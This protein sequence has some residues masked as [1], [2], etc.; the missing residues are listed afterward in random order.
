[1]TLS[2]SWLARIPP[3]SFEADLDVVDA[4]LKANSHA[5]ALQLLARETVL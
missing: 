2:C 1:M 3:I 5:K 4:A